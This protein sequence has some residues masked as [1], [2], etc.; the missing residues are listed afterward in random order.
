L[1]LL[2]FASGFADDDAPPSGVVDVLDEEHATRVAKRKT[3]VA[4]DA[5]L[6]MR[7]ICADAA[8][9]ARRT[10]LTW[11]SGESRPC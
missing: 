7:L 8:R 1:L 6:V 10:R 9:G 4:L 2:A 3:V 5:K 11:P